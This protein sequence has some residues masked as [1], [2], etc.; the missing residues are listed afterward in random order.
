MVW[1]EQE[2][3]VIAR[4]SGPLSSSFEYVPGSGKDR[5]TSVDA[6]CVPDS[7]EHEQTVMRACGWRSRV[8]ALMDS[9]DDDQRPQPT[10]RPLGI[11][12]LQN[13]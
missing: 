2:D 12:N 3:A 5:G 1:I 8:Q 10:K 13:L 4:C 9:K 7:F 11:L 6:P